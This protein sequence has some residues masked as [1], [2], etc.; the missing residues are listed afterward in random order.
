MT[1]VKTIQNRLVS[2]LDPKIKFGGGSGTIARPSRAKLPI[3]PMSNAPQAALNNFHTK[4]SKVDHLQFPLDVTANEGLG[5]HGHYMMFYINAVE[6]AV[7]TTE[8]I[9]KYGNHYKLHL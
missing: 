1:I 5:N 2:L 7:L 3:K 8:E 4:R 6:D 9:D